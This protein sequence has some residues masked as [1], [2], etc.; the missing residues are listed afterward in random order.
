MTCD[1]NVQFCLSFINT[2]TK[3][4]RQ[5]VQKGKMRS[6]VTTD[7]AFNTLNEMTY[8]LTYIYAFAIMFSKTS[9]QA[10]FIVYNL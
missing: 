8:I 4:Y 2:P 3:M 1:N 10:L 6:F 9:T 5:M 7:T